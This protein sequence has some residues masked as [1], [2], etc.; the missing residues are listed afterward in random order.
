MPTIANVAGDMIHQAARHGR[1]RRS[2]PGGLDITFVQVAGQC[3]LTLSRIIGQP[4]DAEVFQWREAFQVPITLKPETTNQGVEFRWP[5]IDD[6]S[7]RLPPRQ[8]ERG[9]A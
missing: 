2:L 6:G 4:E 7:V 5:S 8:Q 1:S 3:I 9:A